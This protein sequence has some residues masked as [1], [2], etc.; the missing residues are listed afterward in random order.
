M[1]RKAINLRILLM[2][3]LN[4]KRL[5][6]DEALRGFLYHIKGIVEASDKH[7]GFDEDL[8]WRVRTRC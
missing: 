2:T 1:L 6:R 8:G 3:K 4:I 7:R 5:E